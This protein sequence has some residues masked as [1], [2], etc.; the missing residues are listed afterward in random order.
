MRKISLFVV[1]AI[2]AC[3]IQSASAQYSMPPGSPEELEATYITSI[4]NRTAAIVASLDL[5][6]AEKSARVH[7]III[8]QYRT[9]RARDEAIDSLLKL[10]GKEVNYKNRAPLMQSESKALHDKFLAKLATEL[11]PEQVEIV[12]NKM[13]YNKVQVTYVA[14]CSIFSDLTEADK[15]EIMDKLKAARE[16]AMDGGSAA[17][18]SAIFQKYKDQIN[19]YL[20]AHGHDVAK[21]YKEWEAKQ[22][23]SNQKASGGAAGDSTPTNK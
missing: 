23:A 4:E 22:Q 12:K 20:N 17:E 18:K 7:D 13:T 14:Y 6:N 3:L 16:E 15:T 9:L 8:A 1:Q 5:N 19:D 2:A 11:T 10:Q 21:A